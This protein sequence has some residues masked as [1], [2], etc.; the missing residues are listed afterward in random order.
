MAGSWQINMIQVNELI[1]CALTFK[2]YWGVVEEAMQRHQSDGQ[3]KRIN[4]ESVENCTHNQLEDHTTIDHEPVPFRKH[5]DNWSI[6]TSDK[7]H[8]FKQI[9]SRTGPVAIVCQLN[10]TCLDRP[11]GHFAQIRKI[12]GLFRCPCRVSSWQLCCHT[13]SK[14]IRFHS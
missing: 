13:S 7:N 10:I 3:V 11:T 1:T 5:R 9:N 2:I 6:H 8:N 4:D 12:I 14:E